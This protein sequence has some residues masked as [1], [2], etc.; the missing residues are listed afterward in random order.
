MAIDI[1]TTQL[2][3]HCNRQRSLEYVITKRAFETLSFVDGQDI[4]LVQEHEFL[5]TSIPIICMHT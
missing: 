5:L 4:V 1:V 3:V 2:D